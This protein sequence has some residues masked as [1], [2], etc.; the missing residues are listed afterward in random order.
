MNE[1]HLSTDSIAEIHFSPYILPEYLS[2]SIDIT[3]RIAN[4]SP[5]DFD[6]QLQQT[7]VLLRFAKS[8]I[9]VSLPLPRLTFHRLREQDKFCDLTVK[10]GKKE[11]KVNRNVV[12]SHSDWFLKACA[13]E[14]KVRTSLL[15]IKLES[16]LKAG[17][18]ANAPIIELPDDDPEEVETML[19]FCYALEY[20]AAAQSPITFD[21]RMYAIGEKY[22]MEALQ[23]YAAH[24]LRQ[25]IT[26]SWTID[27]FGSAV[28]VAY[29][30]MSDPDNVLR[31][32]IL[33]S[34]LA[35]YEDLFCGD[36]AARQSNAKL[37]AD[38][39]AYTVDVLQASSYIG[40]LDSRIHKYLCP[41]EGC[42][43]VMRQLD[44]YF[45]TEKRYTLACPKCKVPQTMLTS[46]WQKYRFTLEGYFEKEQQ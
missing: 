26:T 3:I 31:K 18:E 13:G 42:H 38:I 1:P 21:A 45:T 16:V 8:V 43:Y 19:N 41:A 39:P 6:K 44:S 22:L 32:I 5:T 37:L 30:E 23:S 34:T 12:A 9:H 40:Q 28:H 7:T 4:M 15:S 29:T 2:I 33:E 20:P 11:I 10:C 35:R 17:Q 25:R 36:M 27:D 14:F 46:E 24:S